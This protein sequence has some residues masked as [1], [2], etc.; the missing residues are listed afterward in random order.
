MAACAFWRNVADLVV[1]SINSAWVFTIKAWN[2]GR[3]SAASRGVGCDPLVTM[4]CNDNVA[5]F[6]TMYQTALIIGATVSNYCIGE[7]DLLPKTLTY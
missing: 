3:E 6:V 2:S 4:V 1:A 7:V 5:D